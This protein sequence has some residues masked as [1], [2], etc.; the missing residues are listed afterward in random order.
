MQILVKIKVSVLEILGIVSLFE[1]NL[2]YF[3]QQWPSKLGQGHKILTK[4]LA[5]Q[6]VVF[7]QI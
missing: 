5:C 3:F 7:M 4:I 1:R 2:A 6:I